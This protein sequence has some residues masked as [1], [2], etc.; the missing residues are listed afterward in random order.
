MNFK[1]FQEKLNKHGYRIAVMNHYDKQHQIYLFILVTEKHG[2][3]FFQW[4]GKTNHYK[5]G[6]KSLIFSIENN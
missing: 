2:N 3:Q 5:E 4:E 6:L 1:T